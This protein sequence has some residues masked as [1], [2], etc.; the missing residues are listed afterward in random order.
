MKAVLVGWVESAKPNKNSSLKISAIA[1]IESIEK[2]CDRNSLSSAILKL[3][4]A[5]A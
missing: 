3:R 1:L 4:T 2:Y 5:I